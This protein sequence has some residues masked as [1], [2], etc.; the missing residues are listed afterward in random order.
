MGLFSHWFEDEEPEGTGSWASAKIKSM[1]EWEDPMQQIGIESPWAAGQI[2]KWEEDGTLEALDSKD[3]ERVSEAN[4][5]PP[6]FQ[7]LRGPK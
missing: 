4:H 7:S 1:Q 2:N 3:R 6:I 5:T